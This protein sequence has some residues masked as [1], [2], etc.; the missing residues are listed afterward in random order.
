MQPALFILGFIIEAFGTIIL[1]ISVI[2]VHDSVRKEK[3]ID[4]RVL[5]KMRREKSYAVIGIILVFIGS[6]FQLYYLF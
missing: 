1:G 6:L 3:R 2:L 5:R 4:K